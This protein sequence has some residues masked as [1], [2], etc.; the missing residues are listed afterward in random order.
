MLFA[1]FQTETLLLKWH[2][3]VPIRESLLFVT[4]LPPPSCN[5]RYQK[6]HQSYKKIVYFSSVACHSP[7]QRVAIIDSIHGGGGMHDEHDSHAMHRSPL[8]SAM[9]SSSLLV[10]AAVSGAPSPNAPPPP[11]SAHTALFFFD[12]VFTS[13]FFKLTLYYELLH[14]AVS[15]SPHIVPPRSL[16]AHSPPTLSTWLSGCVCSAWA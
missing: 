10:A 13:G 6:R 3:L 16:A 14:F 12:R 8:G 11:G 5:R 2:S 7:R 15:F 1:V 9:L 4:T